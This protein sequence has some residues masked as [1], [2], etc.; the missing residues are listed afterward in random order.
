MLFQDRFRSCSLLFLDKVL[1]SASKSWGHSLFQ[2][3]SSSSSLMAVSIN[4]CRSLRMPLSRLALLSSNFCS[5]LLSLSCSNKSLTTLPEISQEASL[6]SDRLKGPF[7]CR[8]SLRA[9]ALYCMKAFCLIVIDLKS[10]RFLKLLISLD[11]YS[12]DMPQF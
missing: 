3:M 12:S 6:S 5:W 4:T 11:S 8:S 9:S 1:S 10:C 7:F 2:L